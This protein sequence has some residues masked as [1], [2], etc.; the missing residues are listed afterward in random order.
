[1]LIVDVGETVQDQRLAVQ[2]SV[3]DLH[4]V[5][6]CHLFAEHVAVPEFSVITVEIAEEIQLVIDELDNFKEQLKALRIK[7]LEDGKAIIYFSK[8]RKELVFNIEF[9]FG[10]KIIQLK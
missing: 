5:S 1:M 10:N 7:K 9:A 8:Y 2:I 4:V 6:D 3:A